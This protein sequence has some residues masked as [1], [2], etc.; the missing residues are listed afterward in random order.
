M[1][2]AGAKRWKDVRFGDAG[3]NGWMTKMVKVFGYRPSKVAPVCM[4]PA[5]ENRPSTNPRGCGDGLWGF[6]VWLGCGDGE[7]GLA[8]EAARAW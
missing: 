8:L 2:A 5:F 4:G 3:G 6:R 1:P 7:T